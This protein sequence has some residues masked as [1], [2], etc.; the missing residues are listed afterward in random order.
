MDQAVET[1]TQ[2]D[3]RLVLNATCVVSLRKEGPC[4]ERNNVVWPIDHPRLEVLAL[5]SRPDAPG[6][7]EVK[8][9]VVEM[10]GAPEPD[11][12]TFV[13]DLIYAGHL[14][15]GEPVRGL[16]PLG[17]DTPGT[18]EPADLDSSDEVRI[19]TP[20]ALFLRDGVFELFDHGG[21]VVASLSPSE[22][23]AL[24][25]IT[26][27][28]TLAS[29]LENMPT[30]NGVPVLGA[31]DF[32]RLVGELDA[33]GALM[34]RAPKV[35]VPG[36]D[37]SSNGR[38][39]F[40][41]RDDIAQ[42]VAAEYA[43]RQTA[44]EAERE[45]RTGQKRVKVI[46]VTF[47]LYAPAG[48]G[49]VVAFAIDHEG[50]WLNEHYNF[51]T[52]WI[53]SDDRLEEFT[54]EPAI[55]MCSDYIWSHQQCLVASSKV[56]ALSP[57]SITI[58]GGP[59][60]PIYEADAIAYFEANPHVDVLVRGEGEHTAAE[61]LTAL[62]PVIGTPEPDLSV[63]NHIAGITY[64]HGDQVI[65]TEDRERSMDF[66]AMPSAVLTGLFDMYGE[67]PLSGV[68]L[69]TNRGCPYSCTFCYWGAAT[70]SRIR[71]FTMD[72]ILAEIDW[73]SEK[74]IDSL[75]LADANFG[76]FERDVEIAQHVADNHRATG[77]PASFG[78][79]YAKNTTKYLSRIISILSDA[80]IL[81]T[82]VL[83]LQTMDEATLKTVRR[84]NIKT[85]KYDAIAE[86]MRKSNLPLMVEL[87]MGLPGQ[88]PQALAN[89][90]QE[91]INRSV[92]AR[93][94]LTTLLV[95]S[96]MNAPDY[97]AENEIVTAE[98]LRPGHN[99]VLVS[100]STFTREEYDYML[101]LRLSFMA[102]EN[103][104]MLRHAARFLSH[105]TGRREMDIYRSIN[106]L[107]TRYP[108]RWPALTALDR[109]S[110][111]LMAPPYSWSLVMGDL[112]RMA[113]EELGVADDSALRTVLE[114]QASLLPAFGRS[115]PL[116]LALDHDIVAWSNE[117]TDARAHDPSGAWA[118]RV[119]RLN[120]F[121]PAEL[122]VDDPM[123]INDWAVGIHP[124]L[125]SLGVN[126]ELDSALARAGVTPDRDEDMEQLMEFATAA[127][128]SRPEQ[129]S[130]QNPVPVSIG[131][132][133]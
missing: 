47:D 38:S 118:E 7:V 115:F 67:I 82:G 62:I 128:T 59:D 71:K 93:I 8:D 56:K 72:R 127:V 124:E 104:G 37:P 14:S 102:Y 132:R 98:P 12:A 6:A 32:A 83:S 41:S 125:N 119:P 90:L 76:I 16:E 101:A 50:G 48:L 28:T 13:M 31:S 85:E 33:A 122:V 77:F 117:V 55:Y 66:D 133:D 123:S 107:T 9:A 44:E 78:V 80:G 73:C 100:T 95:N 5:L 129:R 35:K 49:A 94:N 18:A 51:R 24:G 42:Q 84:S 40:T 19:P 75:G 53:W 110:T 4:I 108:N 68:T 131:R 112:G 91:C 46:P 126:W 79:S 111:A 63:L 45:H 121:G 60:A 20:Q 88:T 64:R 120:T 30:A 34:R 92:P 26:T 29:A 61:I 65:R 87:M 116:T 74:K 21:R 43:A 114:V 69:E 105:E 36:D 52:D 109:F 22:V 130:D 103:F 11:L 17:R 2:A 96:P 99:S 1:D 3:P 15:A 23:A 57:D 106:E 54:A 25:T 70:N 113:V 27:P 89:D 39:D 97:M 81:S 10:T 86:E 58:H